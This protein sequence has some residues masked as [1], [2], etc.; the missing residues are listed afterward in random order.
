MLIISDC[1]ATKADWAVIRDGEDVLKFSTCGFNA[2][3]EKNADKLAS[4]LK[5]GL[6]RLSVIPGAPLSLYM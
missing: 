4:S 1:G 5:N 6:E 3:V 2:A